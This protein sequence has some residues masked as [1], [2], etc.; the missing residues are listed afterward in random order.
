MV[1]NIKALLS[2]WRN[3]KSLVFSHKKDS[4][5]K[6]FLIALRKFGLMLMKYQVLYWSLPSPYEIIV[7]DDFKAENYKSSA[8]KLV[9]T[10]LKLKSWTDVAEPMKSGF[11]ALNH[12]NIWLN[13]ATCCSSLMKRIIHLI[14]AWLTFKH[15]FREVRQA[16]FYIFSF[17]QLRMISKLPFWWLYIVLL[18]TTERALKKS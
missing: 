5:M 7:L 10:W 16:A 3:S 9:S 1:K 8:E 2:T 11:P 17:L 6:T 18:W 15:H 4:H 14:S 12:G 13:L